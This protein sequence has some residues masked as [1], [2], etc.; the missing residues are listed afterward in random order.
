MTLP[1]WAQVAYEVFLL[2]GAVA[3]WGLLIRYGGGFRWWKNYPGRDLV[4]TSFVLGM[5]YTYYAAFT[6]WPDL[7]WKIPIRTALFAILTIILVW[8][9]ATFERLRHETRKANRKGP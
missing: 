1:T 2:I 9:W 7:P 4:A 3:C 6:I 5:F 8:R